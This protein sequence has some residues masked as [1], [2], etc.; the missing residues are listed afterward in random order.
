MLDGVV[1]VTP[2]DAPEAASYAPTAAAEPMPQRR[3]IAKLELAVGLVTIFRKSG[4]S[5]STAASNRGNVRVSR[6]MMLVV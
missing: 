3:M 1:K 2:A 5:C 6:F 4:S